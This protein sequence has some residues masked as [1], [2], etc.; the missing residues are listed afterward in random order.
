MPLD[1]NEGREEQGEHNG[2]IRFLSVGVTKEASRRKVMLNT[3]W[4]QCV[5]GKGM[6]CVRADVN[7]SKMCMC[8]ERLVLFKQE[9]QKRLI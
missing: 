8:E 2:E 1:I 4:K 6:V 7:A 9:P 3:V 5:L